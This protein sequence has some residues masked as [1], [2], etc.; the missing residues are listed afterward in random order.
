MD[1]SKIIEV[2]AASWDVL[3]ASSPFILFGFAV[4]GL[5]KGFIPDDFIQRHLGGKGVKS[6]IKASVFG[7]PIPL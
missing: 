1:Y 5:L 2:L 3:L 7:V 4:A 6:L